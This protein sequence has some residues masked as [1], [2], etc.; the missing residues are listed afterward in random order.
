MGICQYL[1]LG[2]FLGLQ[3]VFV[4]NIQIHWTDVYYYIDI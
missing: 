4:N 1:Y 2:N 3:F